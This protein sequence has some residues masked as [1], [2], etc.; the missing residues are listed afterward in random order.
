MTEA[1]NVEIELKFIAT[2]EVAEQLSQRLAP[3]PNVHTAAQKLTNIY[4]CV[5]FFIPL[6]FCVFFSNLFPE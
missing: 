2:P 3:W 6:A 1:M 4:W 5:I